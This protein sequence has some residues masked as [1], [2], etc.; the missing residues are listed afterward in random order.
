M[1]E[2]YPR[3]IEVML[4]HERRTRRAMLEWWHVLGSMVLDIH[5]RK[6]RGRTLQDMIRDTRIPDEEL[7][8]AKAFYIRFSNEEID[9]LVTQRLD[10]RYA[11]ELA[12]CDTILVRRHHLRSIIKEGWSLAELQRHCSYN[13]AADLE[14]VR[15]LKKQSLRVQRRNAGIPLTPRKSRKRRSMGAI[16]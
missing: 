13:L 10:W 11:R 2:W 12:M 14:R 9:R 5:R 6:H 3:R 1:D 16:A 7:L 15:K 8:R 4:D